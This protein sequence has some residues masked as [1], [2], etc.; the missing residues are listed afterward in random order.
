MS[1][2][3]SAIRSLSTRRSRKLPARL[4]KQSGASRVARGA[5]RHHLD[6]DVLQPQLR[7][8]LGAVPGDAVAL[9]PKWANHQDPQATWPGRRIDREATD[10]IF[11]LGIDCNHL[12]SSP[13]LSPRVP[14]GFMRLAVRSQ[15]RTG[16]SEAPWPSPRPAVGQ[17]ARVLECRGSAVVQGAH[18]I[19]G[20]VVVAA[21]PT[22]DG[23]RQEFLLRLCACG[24]V[25]RKLS[26]S[27]RPIPGSLRAPEARQLEFR[28]GAASAWPLCSAD[29][30]A[31]LVWERQPSRSRTQ[32][33][34]RHTLRQMHPAVST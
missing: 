16:G 7:H 2:D 17:T 8:E 32:V 33:D 24:E 11:V 9:G 31:E 19:P 28:F 6:V 3:Q 15:G 18:S 27:S 25:S 12:V 23:H 14:A 26:R 30:R 20:H 1:G 22:L 5:R 4:P 10:R 29:E 13:L 21:V 34:S